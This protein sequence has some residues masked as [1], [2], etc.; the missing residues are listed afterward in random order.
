M[1][2]LQAANLRKTYRISRHNQVEALRGVTLNVEPGEIV[3]IMGPSGSGKST[4]MHIL[5]LLHGPDRNGGPAP[6]LSFDGRDVANLTDRARTHLRASEM[7]FVFQSY[8]LVQTLTAL[9][10]VMLA[11]QYAGVPRPKARADALEALGWVGLADRHRHRPMEMSGG[12]QQR[13]AIAR[14]LV[15]RPKLLLGDEPTG[16]LD[17]QRSA[18]VLQLLRRFNRERGQ[19]VLMVTHDA[20]V[21]AACDRVIHMRDGRCERSVVNQ[22][23]A[24]A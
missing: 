16:N 7:G 19:T 5:G 9:E 21:G 12:E 8:N 2:L 15:N 20:D 10:N 18:E 4:L 14:A 17:S 6:E 24:S 22:P 23:Q 11:G 1:P 13:V 3:A